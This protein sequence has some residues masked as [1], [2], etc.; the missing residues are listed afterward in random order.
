MYRF[1]SNCDQYCL[2][3]LSPRDR[4]G[5]IGWHPILGEPRI[6]DINTL[7][8]RVLFSCDAHASPRR[9]FKKLS[10]LLDG[11]E[12]PLFLPTVGYIKIGNI[13]R[14][15][16]R[17]EIRCRCDSRSSH[18]TAP[19]IWSSI[20]RLSSIAYS[21]GSSRAMGSTKPR[22][23]MAIASSSFMPRDMR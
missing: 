23:I 20:K 1:F 7:D 10:K 11:R 9:R 18:P 6:V 15:D 8:Q 2:C 17:C 21:M 22:T 4:T 3:R 13:T 12:S 16:A 5:A 19:S 14:K